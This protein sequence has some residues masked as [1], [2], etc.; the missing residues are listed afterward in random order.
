MIVRW[1]YSCRKSKIY[2][3]ISNDYVR[4]YYYFIILLGWK[5][6]K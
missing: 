4:P 5:L 6:E 1:K 3:T 2:W